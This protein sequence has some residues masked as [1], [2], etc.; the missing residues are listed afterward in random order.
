MTMMDVSNRQPAV[1]AVYK[2][3]AYGHLPE[4]K[5]AISKRICL[6]ANDMLSEIAD[7][8]ELTVGLRKLLE[9]KDCFVRASI[10]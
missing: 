8:A 5:Q 9:A 2:Y 3:F 10:K 4:D 1:Q 6:T 7:S